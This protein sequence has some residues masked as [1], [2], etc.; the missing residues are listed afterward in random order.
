MLVSVRTTSLCQPAFPRHSG[1]AFWF[2]GI[3]G[4]R[5]NCLAEVGVSLLLFFPILTSSWANFVS[6]ASTVSS[7]V[8][9]RPSAYSLLNATSYKVPSFTHKLNTLFESQHN[10]EHTDYCACLTNNWGYRYTVRHYGPN[11]CAWFLRGQYMWDLA[12][13]TGLS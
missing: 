11:Y 5:A 8:D 12:D 6:N 9:S 2:E 10:T 7:I 4:F 3:E 1:K 13:W